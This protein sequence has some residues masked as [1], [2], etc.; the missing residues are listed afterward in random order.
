MK[1]I[2]DRRWKV[3]HQKL[4]PQFS[5]VVI[6]IQTVG[7]QS[8]IPWHGFDDCDLPKMTRLKIAQHIVEL[9]NR[10]LESL[11]A[12]GKPAPMGGN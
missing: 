7:G 2:F 1:P 9:H 10:S 3:Y 6:E 11:T 8:V 12:T 4:R 5:N